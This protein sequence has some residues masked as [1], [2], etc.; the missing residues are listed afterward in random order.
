M[1]SKQRTL[2]NWSLFSM[3]SNFL[4]SRISQSINNDF[5]SNAEITF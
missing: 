4:H 5:K 1:K 3:N 2:K